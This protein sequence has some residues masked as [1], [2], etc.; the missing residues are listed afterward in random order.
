M[1]TCPLG[2]AD[3]FVEVVADVEAVPAVV[4]SDV[5]E[6]GFQ[7]KLD[8]DGYGMQSVVLHSPRNGPNGISEIRLGIGE[9]NAREVAIL[10]NM[11]RKG[12]VGG[13]CNTIMMAAVAKRNVDLEQIAG[14]QR[15]FTLR[16]P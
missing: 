16:H 9:L 14:S 8:G 7:G 3:G 2:I 4:G 13:Q 5:Q 15:A 6:V 1:E 11:L 12:L 10:R